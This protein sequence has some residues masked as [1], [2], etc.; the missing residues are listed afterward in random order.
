MHSEP[1]TTS[2][3][4]ILA[5]FSRRTLAHADWTHEAHLSVCWFANALLGPDAAMAHL[6]GAIVSFNESIGVVNST[7]SGYHETITRYF[8]EAVAAVDADRPGDLFDHPWCSRAAPL[9][10]WTRVRLF[11]PGARSAWIEPDLDPLPW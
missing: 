1:I 7:D 8:V 2:P 4:A 3:D 9:R 11:S 5:G 10:H 6:R